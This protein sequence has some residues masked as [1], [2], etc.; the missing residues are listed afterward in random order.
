MA[1][2]K[3][4][5]D[6][7]GRECSRCGV[8]KLWSEFSRCRAG[9]NGHVS[10]CK[11]CISESFGHKY[12]GVQSD[13]VINDVGR[14]CTRCKEFKEWIEY[15]SGDGPSGYRSRCLKCEAE[16][17]G[18]KYTG[19]RKRY[20][21]N[22]EGRQCS[23][24]DQY[25]PWKQFSKNSSAFSGHASHCKECEAKSKRKAKFG[26]E[27]YWYNELF[28]KQNGVCAI[29]GEPEINADSRNGEIK[30][31]AV[32]HDHTT[33]EVRGLLCNRCNPA[34]GAFRDDVFILKSAIEYLEKHNKKTKKGEKI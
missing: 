8:Y 1:K 20:I 30:A 5:V 29:C 17:R 4:V 31:L 27:Q 9:T 21:I 32:D 3:G 10:R 14:E 11:K 22:D 6:K 26:I 25:L 16:S 13:C 23:K 33:G 12:G 7:H 18:R 28:A 15:G 24:C 2:T 19:K 34:L